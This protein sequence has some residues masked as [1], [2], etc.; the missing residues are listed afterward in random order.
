MTWIDE[1][2]HTSDENVFQ[3]VLLV[4]FVRNVINT[5]NAP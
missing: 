1:G 3:A 4:C 2:K 5:S